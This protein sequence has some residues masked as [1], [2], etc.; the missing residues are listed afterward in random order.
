MNTEINRVAFK[1]PVFLPEVPNLGFCLAGAKFELPG[2]TQ[3]STKQNYVLEAL[4]LS[5]AKHVMD[6]DQNPPRQGKYEV[7]KQR[8]LKQSPSKHHRASY[9]LNMPDLGDQLLS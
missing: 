7:I 5:A 8:M 3:G 4:D 6:V 1:F 9:L 2:I